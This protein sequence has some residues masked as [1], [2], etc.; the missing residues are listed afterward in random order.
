MLRN[1]KNT[2]RQ[3]EQMLSVQDKLKTRANIRKGI[4]TLADELALRK[5]ADI[6]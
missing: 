6:G 5:H 1:E 3:V 2:R 4:W